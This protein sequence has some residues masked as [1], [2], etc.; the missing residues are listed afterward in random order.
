MVRCAQGSWLGSGRVC[1]RCRCRRGCDHS[2]LNRSAASTRDSTTTT[3]HTSTS[4]SPPRHA[5]SASTLRL[6]LSLSVCQCRINA[7]RGPL[8]T[9]D[10]DLS[11][12]YD[13]R[14]YFNV[15]SK[16]NMSQLNLPHGIYT[17]IYACERVDTR[18]WHEWHSQP[19][20]STRHAGSYFVPIS[21][22]PIFV[23]LQKCVKLLDY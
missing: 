21:I 10:K 18:Q 4:T 20:E 15:R 7:N 13:T 23:L 22:R 16:A 1:G 17:C 5:R 19:L 6:S 3:N 2:A 14:C 9:P 8:L 11:I 12:R